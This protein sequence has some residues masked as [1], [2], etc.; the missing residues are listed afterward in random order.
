MNLPDPQNVTGSV[1]VT[2]LPAVQ[3]VNVTNAP[4]GPPSRFQ[5]VGFTTAT[6]TGDS[7]GVLAFTL[8][9]QAEFTADSRMCMSQEILETVD[10]PTGLSGEAW[11]QP[12][13]AGERLDA[14]GAF[15]SSGA[16]TLTCGLVPTW[17][18]ANDRNGLIVD[19]TG[20]FRLRACSNA[21]SLACCALVP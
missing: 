18:R 17:G 15:T 7:G 5:L 4:P 20:S 3:D 6:F 2:N 1:E 13:F 9:C 10:V 14:S 21:F 11:V 12:T 16:S 8:A 19:S